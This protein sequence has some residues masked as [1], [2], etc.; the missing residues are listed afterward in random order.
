MR[1]AR[2]KEASLYPSI[3]NQ[4]IHKKRTTLPVSL[5]L[6][7]N[8]TFKEIVSKRMELERNLADEWQALEYGTKTKEII[9]QKKDAAERKL[10]SLK[11]E[12]SDCKGEGENFYQVHPIHDKQKKEVLGFRA[13]VGF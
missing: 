3:Y 6:G 7:L 12:L 8:Q 10:T 1:I 2:S 11:R 13:K 9:C 5:F 4:G